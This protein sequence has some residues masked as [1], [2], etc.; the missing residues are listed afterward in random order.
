MSVWFGQKNVDV[1]RLVC[2]RPISA[3]NMILVFVAV[4][5]FQVHESQQKL[6]SNLYEKNELEPMHRILIELIGANDSIEGIH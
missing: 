2:K 5:N 6:L 3:L 1:S 4:T